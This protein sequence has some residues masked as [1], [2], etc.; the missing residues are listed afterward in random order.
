MGFLSGIITATVKTV[1]TPLV[2]VKD[3]LEG[4]LPEGTAEHAEDIVEDIA[5]SVDDLANGDLI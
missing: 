2:V 4:D 1:L 3:V 5:K